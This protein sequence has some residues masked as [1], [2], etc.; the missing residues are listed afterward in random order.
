MIRVQQRF[1]LLINRIG[2]FHLTLK[3]CGIV[4]QVVFFINPRNAEI[5]VLQIKPQRNPVV[6]NEAFDQQLIVVPQTIVD[7]HVVADKIRRRFFQQTF[8]FHGV[9]VP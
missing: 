8:F 2:R 9:I 3:N 6:F 1:H 7:Q 5:I 4:N